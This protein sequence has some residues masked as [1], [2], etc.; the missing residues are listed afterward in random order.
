MHAHH[1]HAHDHGGHGHHHHPAPAPGSRN[2]AFAVG[3]GL[4][5]GFVALQVWFG[6]AV[7]SVALLS[8]AVHNLGDVLGLALSWGAAVLALRRP[9]ARRTYGWGR[10]T[11]LASLLNAVVLLVGVGAVAAEAI[12][13]LLHP[14]PVAGAT[15]AWV[16]ALG[17]VVNGGSALLFAAGRR[18]DLNV[19][20]A[21]THLMADAVLSAGVVAAGVVIVLTGAT[22]LDP[23]ASLVLA[24][25][26][27][28]SSWGL[29]RESADLAMDAMPGGLKA[30]E[31]AGFLHALPGVAEV[32][33]LHVWALSTTR[34]ALTAH[35][36][37]HEDAQPPELVRLACDGL[38]DRF[39][40]DHCTFQVET[41]D[42]AHAC[43]L[44][45]EH[46]V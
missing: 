3:T 39:G 41:P 14:E 42:H 33:D 5:A 17:I 12:R 21:F 29:L 6:L 23:A 15:V 43:A 16:A 4:N 10:G 24:A 37:Q 20:A 46:V 9:T 44:R 1:D 32:H 26:I 38:R 45:P 11:I 22:W 31:I 40:I 2:L 13:R 28:W 30:A 35:L 34:T 8:D 27:A 7:G 36:V 25:M 19:R 18:G